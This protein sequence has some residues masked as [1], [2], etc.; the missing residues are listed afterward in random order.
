MCQSNVP[1]DV[2]VWGGGGR[3]FVW[4]F[5]NPSAVQAFTHLE[6]VLFLHFW[7]T[8]PLKGFTLL[9]PKT[10]NTLAHKEST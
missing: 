7:I 1:H 5:D 3:V 6:F 2:G 4:A 9:I 8:D 10:M